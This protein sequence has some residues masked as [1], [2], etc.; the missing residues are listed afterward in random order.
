MDL[1]HVKDNHVDLYRILHIHVN[2]NE[3]LNSVTPTL[4]NKQFRKLSLTLH[5]DKSNE[6]DLNITRDRWDN[7][8]SA[9]R[10]L[11]EHK[12]EYDIWYQRTFLH[13]NRELLEKLEISEKAKKEKLISYDE[14]EKIQRYGQTLRKL[15][16]F[17]IPISDWRNPSFTE[18]TDDLNKLTETCLF[19][20]KLVKRKEYNN[21]QK[22][23][24]WFRKIDIPITVQYY[25]EN[26]DQR[27]DDLV[28][29][30]SAR[31]LQTTIEI[32]RTTE[33]EK[34]LHPDILEFTPAVEFEHF[35]FKEKVE[36][37]P[38]LSSIIYNS[39][40]NAIIM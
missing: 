36:L 25:S 7:L 6:S 13:S 10:I 4:I 14:I 18:N 12:K 20:I 37:D 30:A 31:N 29:Y 38:S 8:Q 34:E 35:S 26:N 3:H 27:E 40:D 23:N 28:V 19:R 5:P 16:H 15:V 17:E 11:S 33:N 22:L 32:F 9:Y 39:S 1:A 24:E 2:D 21:E